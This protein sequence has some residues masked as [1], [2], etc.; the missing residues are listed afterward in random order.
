MQQLF[1]TNNNKPH[2]TIIKNIICNIYTATNC[3]RQIDHFHILC[4]SVSHKRITAA[5]AAVV[6]GGRKDAT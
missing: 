3:K 6:V 2:N 4:T 1:S 5:A